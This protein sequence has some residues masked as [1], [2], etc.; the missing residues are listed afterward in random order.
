MVRR[1][2]SEIIFLFSALSRK[3]EII[4][5]IVDFLKYSLQCDAYM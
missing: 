5:V 3:I 4:N 2:N 1:Q